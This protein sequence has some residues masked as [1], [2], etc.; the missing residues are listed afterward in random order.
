MK[1]LTVMLSVELPLELE[2]ELGWLDFGFE[3]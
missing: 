2:V 1:T 3:L